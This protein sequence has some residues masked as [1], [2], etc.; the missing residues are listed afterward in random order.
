MRAVGGRV[1][2]LGCEVDR[3]DFPAAL[4]RLAAFLAGDRP[5]LVITANAEILYAAQRHDGLRQAL[6]EADLVVPDGAGVVLASRLLGDPLPVRVAGVDLVRRFLP[7]VARQG[8]SV[9]LLGAA[10]GVAERA[11]ERLCAEVPGLRIAGVQH[12]YFRPEE[13]GEVLRKVA[14]SRPG[15]L[16]VGL[17][18]PRQELWLHRHYRDLGARVNIPV[19]GSLDVYAG[20]APRAPVAMQRL[21]LEWLYRLWREPWRFRRMLALPKFLVAAVRQG[22][23]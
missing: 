21:G 22:R 13:E 14:S 19:G 17:G 20:V 12:G 4:E 10:P 15:V 16:L 23:R 2:I 9:F 7:E 18:S 6:A 1:R 3:V 11:A 8:A 5:R